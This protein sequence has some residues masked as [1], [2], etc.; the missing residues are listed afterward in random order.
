MKENI[1]DKAQAIVDTGSERD[2]SL[3]KYLNFKRS[4][5][6]LIRRWEGSIKGRKSRI[7]YLAALVYAKLK[8]F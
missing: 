8:D 2:T 1:Q 3:V 4:M 7:M 5:R 6:R